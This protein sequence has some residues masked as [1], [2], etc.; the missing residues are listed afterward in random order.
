MLL[1]RSNSKKGPANAGSHPVRAQLRAVKDGPLED[2]A[3][4]P[5]RE[6]SP[7]DIQR[8]DLDHGLAVSVDRMEMRWR[9]ILEEHSDL[10]SQEPGDLR[11]RSHL[12]VPSRPTAPQG[13]CT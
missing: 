2:Q 10:D 3:A 7:D 13:G 11:Q 6:A 12:V 1:Q 8:V 9:V 4:D 5:R